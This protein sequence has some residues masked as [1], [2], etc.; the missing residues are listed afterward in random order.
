[1]I[2]TISILI[3]THNYRDGAA[4]KNSAYMYMCVYT[5]IFMFSLVVN[6]CD[7]CVSEDEDG[8]A[9]EGAGGVGRGGGGGEDVR[10][11]DV[12]SVASRSERETYSSIQLIKIP[13]SKKPVKFRYTEPLVHS[14]LH[15]HAIYIP[16]IWTRPPFG[17]HVHVRVAPLGS[18]RL[19]V[20]VCQRCQHLE[21]VVLSKAA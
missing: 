14:Y 10:G 20:L 16:D 12:D 5:Y 18:R 1:M 17:M 13:L 7:C 15:N 3:Y 6:S 2:V 4:L 8:L 11:E 9:G 21:A 19:G